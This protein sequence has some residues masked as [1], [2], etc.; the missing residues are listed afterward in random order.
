MH[1]RARDL[2]KGTG[3]RTAQKT[4]PQLI[5]FAQNG[6]ATVQAFRDP[7]R[8]TSAHPAG[9]FPSSP[10][11]NQPPE[12]DAHSP[13]NFQ[14][15]LSPAQFQGPVQFQ[16]PEQPQFMKSPQN[17][18]RSGHEQGAH[19]SQQ[20]L[21]G[22]NRPPPKPGT[23]LS[24]VSGESSELSLHP[25]HGFVGICLDLLAWQLTT[26]NCSFEDCS[27]TSAS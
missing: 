26:P 19:S 3:R 2:H 10:V 7:Q 9:S 13:S 1:C 25:D 14:G 20:S 27:G 18:P 4:A 16:G 8:T 21:Q 17:F 11:F 24:H 5:P 6:A 23:L 15:Q 22:N 12:S